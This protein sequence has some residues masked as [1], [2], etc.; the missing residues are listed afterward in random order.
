M[1][2][3]ILLEI[4][5]IR[6]FKS[7]Y[8]NKLKSML[9]TS[10][11]FR[12]ALTFTFIQPSIHTFWISTFKAINSIRIVGKIALLTL[13]IRVR[14]ARPHGLLT[15]ISLI[16]L[17]FVTIVSPI[18]DIITISASTAEAILVIVTL[19]TATSTTIHARSE[20]RKIISP[21]LSF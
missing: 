2:V 5:Q 17:V 7:I 4:N 1:T 21:I 14:V 15:G 11:T 3:K 20:E 16:R 19:L 12:L 6:F 10:I 13:P 18:V 9:P 8:Q